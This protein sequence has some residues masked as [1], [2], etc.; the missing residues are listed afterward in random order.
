ME[1][2]VCDSV[3]ESSIRYIGGLLSAYELSGFAYPVLVEK[4]KQ[5]AD[6]LVYAWVG[7]K[8]AGLLACCCSD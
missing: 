7:V 4:S 2:N 8:H 6:K 1:S 3:F 5:L